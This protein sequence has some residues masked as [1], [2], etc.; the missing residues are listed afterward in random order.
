[1]RD[2]DVLAKFP[3]YALVE[4]ILT[5]SQPVPEFQFSAQ[6]VESVGREL[7]LIV[8]EGKDAKTALDQAAA[9]LAELAKKANLA[10]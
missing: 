3:Y 5:K 2:K 9:D 4:Q 7:S 10:K 1:M 6:M 8:A